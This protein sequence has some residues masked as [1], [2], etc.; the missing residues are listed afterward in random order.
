MKTLTE[1]NTQELKRLLGKDGHPVYESVWLE[2]GCINIHTQVRRDFDRGTLDILATDIAV[3]GLINRPN[4][5]F[6]PEKM[7]R[8]HLKTVNTLHDVRHAFADLVPY[9]WKGRNGYISLVAGERRSRAIRILAEEGC[10]RCRNDHRAEIAR[11]G[12]FKACYQRHF[13]KHKTTVEIQCDVMSGVSP[14][15]ALLI[16]IS[17]NLYEKPGT[18]AEAQ[19]YAGFYKFLKLIN[20]D[21]TVAKFC[22]RVARSPETMRSFVGFYDLPIDIQKYFAGENALPFGIAKQLVRIHSVLSGM[23][24]EPGDVARQV[25]NYFVHAV[26]GNCKVGAFTK[27]VSS[28]LNEERMGEKGQMSLLD[29]MSENAQVVA[30]PKFGPIIDPRLVRG[31]FQEKGYIDRITALFE[32]GFLT[33]DDG[34]LHDR[35]AKATLVALCG[36]NK[37]LLGRFRKSLDSETLQ[38]V[39]EFAKE[40]KR[41]GVA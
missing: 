40:A 30:K 21:Y 34:V 10:L 41:L 8:L 25:R 3:N 4:V 6:Y 17:E 20:P 33:S 1:R 27:I 35:K 23:G 11:E 9:T 13:G 7:S 15:K 22:R 14:F 2:L 31:L 38:E 12:A 36:S 28:F 37:E 5:V 32:D 19:A 29:L 24:R 26:A 16:Q 18:H 39:R